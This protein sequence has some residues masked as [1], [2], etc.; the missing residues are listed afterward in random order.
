MG[1][2]ILLI[3]SLLQY[4]EV[5]FDSFMGAARAISIGVFAQIGFNG[6]TAG[7][8]GIVLWAFLGLAVAAH[9]YYSQQNKP[10]IKDL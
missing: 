9:R 10:G 4:P 2:I 8:F 1:G 5:R 6:A 7:V 3:F